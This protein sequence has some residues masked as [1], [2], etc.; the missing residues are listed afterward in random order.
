MEGSAYHA[1]MQIER[2]GGVGMGGE[3]HQYGRGESRHN[4]STSSHKPE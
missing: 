4:Y 2:G 3:T 1:G